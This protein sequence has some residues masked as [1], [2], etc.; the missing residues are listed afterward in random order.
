MGNSILNKASEILPYK[1]IKRI[2]KTGEGRSGDE[3][4]KRRNRRNYRGVMQYVTWDKLKRGVLP[5]HILDEYEEGYVVWVSP[6]EYFGDT[7]PNRSPLL[8]KDFILGKT[9]FVYYKSQDELL[10]YPPLSDWRE[11]YELSTKHLDDGKREWIGE[12]CYNVKNANPQRVSDICADKKAKRDKQD[13]LQLLKDMGVDI[14]EY[15]DIPDQCGI[16]NYDYDYA[17]QVM[18]DN[19]KL[20]MLYLLLTCEDKNGI[21]FG[22]YIQNNYDSIKDEGKETK[23]FVNL[24]KKS[25]YLNE[26][27]SFFN[28]LEKECK[29]K[30]LLDYTK[31]MNING[32]DPVVKRPICPLCSKP[33][34]CEDF[35]KE[36][37]QQEGRRVFD[38]TQREVVLMHVNA[39][40][41]G[42]L[43]HRVYNLS[44]GHAFCN[45]IQ[46]DKDISETIDELQQIINNYLKHS[47]NK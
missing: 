1:I 23:A 10:K 20:Q 43:N 9:G 28:D 4:Y 7:Y 35:F 3:V 36:I 11:L 12:A 32:W 29:K 2:N 37:E 6:S 24:I 34:S 27:R 33:L 39:L 19:V 46:G 38:N 15:K 8:N 30:G 44:W 16:G 18:K 41:P 47:E 17:S 21:N 26:Y 22:K 42:R 13:I 25:N 5:S 31:L 14:D 40:R 45:T